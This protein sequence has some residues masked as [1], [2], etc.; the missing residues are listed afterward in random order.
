MLTPRNIDQVIAALPKVHAD[1]LPAPTYEK[2]DRQSKGIALA[3]E[4]MSKHV[5]NEG[6]QVFQGLEY[7]GYKLYGYNIP[8]GN[9]TDVKEILRRE[10]SATSVVVNDEREWNFDPRNYREKNAKFIGIEELAQRKDLFIGTILKDAQQRTAFHRDSAQRMGAHFWVIHYHPRIVKH[11]ATYVRVPH[12]IRTYHTVDKDDVPS[13]SAK[14][15]H[16]CLLSG[17]I[18]PC[19]PLRQRLF[20]EVDKLPD[21][22]TLQHPGY[23]RNGCHTPNYLNLLSKFQVAIC[24]SSI[25]SY[26]VRKIIEATAAGCMVITDLALDD[27]LPYIDSNLTRI[28][29]NTP[30]A[31]IAELIKTLCR[32]YDPK[33]QQEYTEKALEFYDFR[34]SGLRLSQDIENL[35]LDY[36]V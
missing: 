30:T 7:A 34:V 21:T 3:V 32:K 22:M 33:V 10:P 20:R 5:S 13:Y 27:A 29:P 35:R 9:T 24:T 25:Y 6:F 4:S 11:L 12:L 17:F 2:P 19:Y 31:E 14:D 26:A 16:G 18:W 28:H 8:E 15:R 36:R 1:I 23:S